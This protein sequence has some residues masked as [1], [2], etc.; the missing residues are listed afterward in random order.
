MRTFTFALVACACAAAC[1]RGNGTTT[2]MNS[3]NPLVSLVG[4]V[5]QQDDGLV[6]TASQRNGNGAVGTAGSTGPRRYRLVDEAHTGVDRY[7]D[8]QVQITGK[9]ERTGAE[10]SATLPTIR[11][12]QMSSIGGCDQQ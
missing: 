1:S 10:E 9:V 2:P 5:S 8:R 3:T 11:V 7:V 6:L 4:C 12:T